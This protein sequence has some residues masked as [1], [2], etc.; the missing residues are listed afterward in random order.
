M[1]VGLPIK[2]GL[3]ECVVCGAHT[4]PQT[5][6]THQLRYHRRANDV[7]AKSERPK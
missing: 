7:P 5:S 1:R 4:L 2:Q 3:V 6:H